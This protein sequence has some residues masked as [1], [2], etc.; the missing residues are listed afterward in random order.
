MSYTLESIAKLSGVSRGTVS[1]V[2]NNQP[3]VKP[4][5]RERVL[6]VIAET[7]YVPNPQARSL[8]GGRT[9]NIGVVVFGN[10]PLFLSHH[11]FFEVLQGIQSHSTLNAYDLV[12][13]S[14]RSDRDAEYWKRIGDKRK[15]DGLIIMGERIQE[16]YLQYYYE[17][18]IPFVLVGK[19][20][21][22]NIPLFCVTSDYR[23][24]AYEGTK[25]L[26]DQGQ[27]KIV[28]IRGLLNTYHENER[29]AGY[30]QALE[31]AGLG[32]DE[33]LMLYGQ[34]EKQTAYAEMS[35][36]LEGG[37]TFDGVFSGNDLMAFGA[38]EAMKERGLR[39]PQDV[40]VVGYDD[41]E[42]AQYFAPPL[43][44]VRQD[45]RRIGQEAT[46]LLM[47]LLH[48]QID[49]SVPSD[50][51]IDSRLVIRDSSQSR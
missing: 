17:R 32:P 47:K 28:L 13:F 30:V 19:R 5:V 31:E 27:R 39:I 40:A 38:S 3:G 11:L 21:S 14:N 1:R 6:G 44:S 50:I 48:N 12:L 10:S 2:I 8:A 45:K 16:S 26:L 25:H 29:Y 15:V 42:A 7:G 49:R 51:I 46:Q 43:T 22:D 4:A 18:D 34:A 35:R 33:S 9:E 36:L 37:V 41:I 23:K 20:L 24:G